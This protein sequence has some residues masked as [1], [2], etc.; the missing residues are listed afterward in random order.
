MAGIYIHIPFCK[1]RCIYCGFFSSTRLEWKE[2]YV[3]AICKELEMRTDYLGGEEI[4]T[5]YFGGGTPSQL[6]A[7]QISMVLQHISKNYSVSPKAEIT[8]EVNPDDV[9]DSFLSSLKQLTRVNRISMGIQ[10]FNDDRLRFLNR[11]HNAQQ[12]IEAV[13][14]LKQNGF[15]NI[16][17]DLMFG[18]PNQ[19]LEE[20][21]KD[22][23]KAIDMNVQHI[24]AYSL[25]YEEDTS[26]GSMLQK[27]EVEEISDELS[28][29]MYKNLMDKLEK[30]G[31][32]HYEI[33]NFAKP[34]FHS[35]HNSSYWNGTKYLGIGATAHSY[36]GDTRQWNI[37]NIQK[38]CQAIESGKIE[39]EKEV[40]TEKQKYNEY[41]MTRLRTSEGINLKDL[42]ERFG[43]TMSETLRDYARD[44]IHSDLLTFSYSRDFMKLTKEGIYLSN[45]VMSTLFIE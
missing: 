30:A 38:Y 32:I 7:E 11:R 2:R 26:L 16:S 39:C 4:N 15:S 24:S 40:L 6:S 9:S 33:S 44:L 5:I 3:D 14:L 20:W 10:T 36:D 35:R 42:E 25:M 28:S 22:I 1:T 13:K 8:L 27:G 18:F 45:Q 19:T 21:G 29:E 37:D 34:N 41:I 17:I 23:E 31:F 12:A 43:T